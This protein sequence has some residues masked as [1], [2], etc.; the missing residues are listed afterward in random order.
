MPSWLTLSAGLGCLD[1]NFT[2]LGIPGNFDPCQCKQGSASN[3]T[4]ALTFLPSLSGQES[5]TM[6]LT[7]QTSWKEGFTTFGNCLV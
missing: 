7:L 2:I 5:F 1:M 6:A 3:F 4:M